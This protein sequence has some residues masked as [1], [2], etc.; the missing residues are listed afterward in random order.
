MSEELSLEIDAASVRDLMASDCDVVLIDVREAA[1]YAIAK[2]EGSRLYPM[3]EI[4]DK[5]DELKA[6]GTDRLVVHCHHGGRSLQVTQWMRANGIAQAQNM[7]GGI[8]GWS[9]EIDGDVPR[10]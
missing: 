6:I 10:Y 9:L 8:D 2:I 5:L 3:S 1:E 7:S 4:S